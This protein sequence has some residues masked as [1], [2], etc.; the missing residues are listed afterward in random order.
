VIAIALIL[1]VLLALV[2][3]LISVVKA[4]LDSVESHKAESLGFVR[5]LVS[6]IFAVVIGQALS[7]TA[8]SW[9]WLVIIMLFHIL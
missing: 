2:T 9:Y 5:L 3:L 4:A 7:P 6:G 1:A 8:L